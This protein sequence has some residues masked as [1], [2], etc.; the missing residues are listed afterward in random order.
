M[1]WVAGD[2][3]VPSGKGLPG[4]ASERAEKTTHVSLQRLHAWTRA[5]GG[6]PP[7]PEAGEPSVSEGDS[8]PCS[9]DS[10][11]CCDSD[12]EP[13]TSLSEPL[14]P[15]AWTH[16]FSTGPEPEAGPGPLA[17]SD[18]IAEHGRWLAACIQALE[19][20]V[21]EE[22][23]ARV[24]RAVDGLAR[25][26]MFTGRL[27]A[28]RRDLACGRDGAGLRKVL[29]DKLSSLR[30]RLSARRPAR[31]GSSPCYGKAGDS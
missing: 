2:G 30:R 18:A 17:A 10:G 23:L 13:G 5:T 9:A 27:P 21:T 16:T 26:E 7:G 11:L 28:V 12:S 22:E 31:A 14:S 20:E 8:L 1:P 25:W 15:D 3:G 19:R 4:W 6:T 24:D 29:G